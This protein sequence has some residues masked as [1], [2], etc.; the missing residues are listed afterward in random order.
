MDDLQDPKSLVQHTW[1]SAQVATHTK[2][3]TNVQ[4][5]VQKHAKKCNVDARTHWQAEARDWPR[6]DGGSSPPAVTS[7]Q[8]LASRATAP[9]IVLQA[10]PRVSAR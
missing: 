5:G 4:A 7:A 6:A 3:H 8:T 2:L 1:I 10:F 9:Y